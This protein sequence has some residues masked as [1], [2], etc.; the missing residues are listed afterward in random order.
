MASLHKDPRGKSPFWYCAF[1]L[2][3]G[4][5]T[6]RSTKLTERKRAWELCLQWDKAA[7]QARGGTFN[8]AQARKVLNTIL[9]STGQTPMQTETV[10]G[11]FT[12]WL[13]GKELA[14]KPGTAER[15]RI[16]VNRFLAAMGQKA[17]QPLAALTPRDLEA[18]RDESM[19]EGKAPKT[20]AVEMKVLRTVLNVA[21]RQGQITANPAEAVE[22]PKVI[23][24]TRDVF[25]PEQI[26]R[27]LGAASD[28]WKTAIL[29][30]YCLGARLG[31]AIHMTW[32][33]VDLATGVITYEQQK[34][35]KSVTSPIHPDLEAHL[36]KLAGDDPRACLC[37]AL[38]RRSVGGR[39]GL[40]QTFACVMRAA[41]IDQQQVKGMGKEGRRFSKLSFHSLRHTFTS[42]LANAG[43]PSEVRQKLTGHADAATHQKYT[44]LELQP[45]QEA[46]AKL[47]SVMPEAA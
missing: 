27:L 41:G 4:R 23:S 47:P 9:E 38:Q 35:G 1:T 11:Y 45:L 29:L 15:Y 10:Q 16:V 2:P 40:S 24:H 32:E 21:R 26:R 22:L 37:P 20:V 33:S 18:F 17:R 8:E 3:D 6:F 5:R 14:K 28:E 12:N 46:I 13:S 36:S 19:A 30:G 44:H 43:V 25:S 34:T 39:S 42:A 31:D 7:E